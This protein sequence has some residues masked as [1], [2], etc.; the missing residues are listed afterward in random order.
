MAKES[1]DLYISNLY[2]P[3]TKF[4]IREELINLKSQIV[5]S[6][7]YLIKHSTP[8]KISDLE[9]HNC[10]THQH[11]QYPNIWRFGDGE[12]IE[13]HSNLL[14]NTLN[15]IVKAA[16]SGLGLAL[17]PKLYIQQESSNQELC[18]VLPELVSYEFKIYTYYNASKHR[19]NVISM[20]LDF[21]KKR[22]TDLIEI[23]CISLDLI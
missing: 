17:V 15:N 21:L 6:P 13:I 2:I 14:H 5:A 11:A 23:K 9:R 20:F 19:K 22:V 7:E 3:T 18:V 10:I 4:I 16:K 8:H 12:L 1:L